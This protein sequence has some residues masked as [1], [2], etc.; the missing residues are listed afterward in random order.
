MEL[1]QN[2]L[3]AIAVFLAFRFLYVKFFKKDKTSGKS[4]GNDDCGC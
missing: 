4:C 3:V 2:I 1:F